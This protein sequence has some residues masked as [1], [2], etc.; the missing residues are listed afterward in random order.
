MCR[1][2]R[3][4]LLNRFRAKGKIAPGAWCQVGNITVEK[5]IKRDD[6]AQALIPWHVTKC[7]YMVFAINLLRNLPAHSTQELFFTGFELIMEHQ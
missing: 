5:I 1:T 3:P 4:L 7:R 2:H 6:N